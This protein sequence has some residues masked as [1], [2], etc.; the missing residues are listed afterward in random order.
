MSVLGSE[1]SPFSCICYKYGILIFDYK[2]DIINII[3]TY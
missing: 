3:Y 1:Q 2:N